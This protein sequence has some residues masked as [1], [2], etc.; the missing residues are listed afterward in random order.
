MYICGG[1]GGV[2]TVMGC[3]PRDCTGL[4][5]IGKVTEAALG[6]AR[7]AV[8]ERGLACRGGVPG[9]PTSL[10]KVLTSGSLNCLSMAA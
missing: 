8:L 6:V 10:R 2:I 4:F 7:R 1:C 3:W 9:V 5:A